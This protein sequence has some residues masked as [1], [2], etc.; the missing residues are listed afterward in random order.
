MDRHHERGF[1]MGEMLVVLILTA[2]TTTMAMA[3]LDDMLHRAALRSAASRVRLLLVRTQYEAAALSA[4]RAVKFV[5]KAAACEYRIYDDGNGNGV[6]NAETVS[7][8]DPLALG[9]DYLLEVPSL[10]RVGLP[11]EDTPDPDTGEPLRSAI[12]F[13]QSTLCSFAPDGSATPGT[14]YLTDGIG[15]IAV[16]SSGAD[17]T[18]RILLYNRGKRR[19]TAF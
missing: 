5:P 18:I 7:G 8:V 4:Y 9:P 2:I 16:R 3:S 19:W 10:V 6:R 1:T 14:I 13:N 17:G 12:N 11:E 15:A